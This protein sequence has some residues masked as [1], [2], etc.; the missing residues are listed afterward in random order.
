MPHVTPAN[1]L[2]YNLCVQY[3]T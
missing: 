3:F 2:F 1:P